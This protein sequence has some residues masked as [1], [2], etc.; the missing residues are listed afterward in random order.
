MQRYDLAGAWTLS[1]VDN[2]VRVPA[3]VPG[4]VYTDLL[5]AGEIA[6]PFHRLNEHALQWVGHGDWVYRRTFEADPQLLQRERILL[7]CQGLD[8]FAT[9]KLNG[10]QVGQSDNMFR[11]WEF[12]V[13]PFLRSGENELEVRFDS[14]INGSLRKM[15]EDPIPHVWW[16]LPNAKGRAWVRKEQCQFGWDWGP[17]LVTAGIWRPIELVGFSRA[18]LGDVLVTQDHS[19][20]GRAV[21]RV[22]AAVDRTSAGATRLNAVLRIDGQAVTEGEVEGKGKRL[23]LD[24]AVD[25]PKLWWPAGMGEQPL[26]NLELTLTDSAGSVLDTSEQ[27]IGLRTLRLV[28]EADEWGESFRF[29]SNGVPFFAKGANWI[30]ADAFLTRVTD[31]HRRDLLQSAVDA[32]MNMMRVWGGGIYEDDAFFDACDELGLC[33]WQDFMFACSPYP[34]HDDH[35]MQNVER[36]AIDNLQRLRNHACLCLW[37]GNNELEWLNIADEPG[38]GKMSWAQYKPLFDRLLPKLCAK[39][40]P[41]VDYWPCSPHK[42]IGPREDVDDE[43]SGDN[44]VW[45]VWHKGEDFEWFRET[46]PRFSSEFGFQSFPEPATMLPCLDPDAGDLNLTSEAV[47]QRQR[48]SA[49][50]GQILHDMARWFR[51]PRGFE[52]SLWLT[53]ILQALCVQTGVEHWRRCMP[54]TMGALYWQLNDCWPGASWSSVDYHGRWKA[55]HYATKR[56]FAPVMVSGV[57]DAARKRITVSVVSDLDRTF[58]GRLRWV[59][60]DLSGEVFDQGDKAF[61]AP[62]RSVTEALSV[63]LAKRKAVAGRRDTVL[64]QELEDDNGVVSHN[65]TLLSRPKHMSLPDPQLKAAVKRRRDGSYRVAIKAQKTALWAWI[66]HPA[67]DLRCSDNFLHMRPGR[68]VE[69]DMRPR[70]ELAPEDFEQ[71]L[72]VRSLYDLI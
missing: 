56:F 58:K 40:A 29:E 64:W 27:R 49:G 4:C 7:R 54:Q 48:S 31:E 37:C 57:A 62:A 21:V 22:D 43:R 53:Q 46:K 61:R 71:G 8:T 10:R 50:T 26:Y 67:C 39:H 38:D 72:L 12:E 35:F 36:E 16:D 17:M 15:D 28:R 45:G 55:L 18:R 65:A 70:T 52:E 63:D 11:A 9:V 47:D 60:T 59:L 33:V 2:P 14:A 5:S 68:K 20:P 23:A 51:M 19:K 25:K 69:L 42:T 13:G 41:Q 32:N 44:H 24:L 6:D 66:S 30:P 1:G 34:T 3:T